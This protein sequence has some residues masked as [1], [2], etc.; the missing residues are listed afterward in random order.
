MYPDNMDITYPSNISITL[1]SM[2]GDSTRKI[3]RYARKYIHNSDPKTFDSILSDAESLL[4]RQTE[5]KI[6]SAGFIKGFIAETFGWLE[7][8]SDIFFAELSVMLDWHYPD[9]QKRAIWALGQIRLGIPDTLLIQL[10]N[11]R[12]LSPWETVRNAAD[13]TLAK[14][15]DAM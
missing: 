14:I 12:L 4:N 7:F 2:L 10:Q 3:R 5:D 1:E 11:L 15:Y 6:F 13:D 9:V 8:S